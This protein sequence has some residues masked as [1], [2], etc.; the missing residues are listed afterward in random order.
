MA[1]EAHGQASEEE[2]MGAV[3]HCADT[4]N[5]EMTLCGRRH[6]SGGVPLFRAS[7]AVRNVTCGLCKRNP[8]LKRALAQEGAALSALTEQ[9]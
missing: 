7:T 9:Q 4:T 5:Y 2:V 1:S 8:R 3:V 6:S